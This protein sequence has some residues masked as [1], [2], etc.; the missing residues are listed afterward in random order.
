MGG[1]IFVLSKG[2]FYFNAN[3]TADQVSNAVKKAGLKAE[4]I[5]E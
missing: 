5:E 1:I 3:A 2:N 4:V